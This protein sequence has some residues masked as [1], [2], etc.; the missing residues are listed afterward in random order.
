MFILPFIQE[1]EVDYR[2]QRV[3]KNIKDYTYLEKNGE[4]LKFKISVPHLDITS[5][6]ESY[7]LNSPMKEFHLIRE[8]Q[9]K[10][11]GWPLNLVRS[12]GKF[13]L[14]ENTFKTKNYL[15]PYQT[16]LSKFLCE[17]YRNVGTDVSLSSNNLYT[18]NE[19]NKNSLDE[20]IYFELNIV[21]NLISKLEVELIEEYNVDLKQIEM[22]I[23]NIENLFGNAASATILSRLRWILTSSE[24]NGRFIKELSIED[25]FIEAINKNKQIKR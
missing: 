9:V 5:C 18:L 20:K 2:E 3:N 19:I 7:I 16:N 8:Q 24:Q 17:K 13:R 11:L 12:V 10:A 1:I 6:L 15:I 14:K 4:I 25:K 23:E 22:Y 21:K